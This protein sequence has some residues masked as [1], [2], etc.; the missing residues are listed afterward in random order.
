MLVDVV[1]RAKKSFPEAV[2]PDATVMLL[3][4]F[5]I[6]NDIAKNFTSSKPPA[7]QQQPPVEPQK[8]DGK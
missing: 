3:M 4:G 5:V 7:V 8:P 1:R 2:A 6:Y